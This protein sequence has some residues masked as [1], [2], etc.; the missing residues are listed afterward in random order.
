ME[1]LCKGVNYNLFS[2]PLRWKKV[3][4]MPKKIGVLREFDVLKVSPANKRA[5]DQCVEILRNQGVEIV[6]INLNDIIDEIILYTYAS[7]L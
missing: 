6:D 2:A 7:F 5:L 4:D 3:N 1:E